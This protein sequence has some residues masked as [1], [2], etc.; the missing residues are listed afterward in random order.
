MTRGEIGALVERARRSE[1]ENGRNTLCEDDESSYALEILV[2][3]IYGSSAGIMGA[4]RTF[5]F[6]DNGLSRPALV[7]TRQLRGHRDRKK[8]ARIYRSYLDR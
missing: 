1:I 3:Y 7:E 6:D 5:I 8:M 4:K 2:L